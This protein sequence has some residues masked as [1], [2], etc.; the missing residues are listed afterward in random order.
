M[1]VREPSAKYLAAPGFKQTEVG[2]IPEDWTLQPL[3]ALAHVTSGKRLPPGYVL[4]GDPTPHPYIRVTDMRAGTVAVDDI[5]FVPRDAAEGIKRYRIW[6]DDLFISVAGTLGIVG[7]VPE[8]LNGANLT[9]NADR[10][11][12]IRCSRDYLLH[13]LLAPGIQRGIALLQTVGAQPKLALERI[14]KFLI[15]LPP[16]REEQVAIAQ[17][18]TDADALIE[19]LEQLFAKK[20]QIK[21]GAMQEL[22]TGQRRLPGFERAWGRVPLGQTLTIRHGKSQR[23]VEAIGGPFPILASGGVIGAATGYIYDKPSVL[24]GRKGTIN[25]PQ[26]MDS[27]FWSVDTLFFSEVMEPNVPKYLYYLFCSINWTQFNEGSG[28]PSLNA[29]TIE[30]VEVLMPEHDEQAAIAD[31]LT[32]MDTELAGLETKLTKA[33]HLKQAMMQALLTGRIR[34]APPAAATDSGV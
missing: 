23:G 17:A 10:I 3:D 30:A 7:K 20:R 6:T 26:Y 21:Q 29:S 8:S 25:Q 11:T 34:L 24:I 12:D 14:R 1:D 19:S 28:V 5:K 2:L 16:A 22:L 15:V 31:V 33:R 13:V 27:P 4:T 18:L 9:E 32:A